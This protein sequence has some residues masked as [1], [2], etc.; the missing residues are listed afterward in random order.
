MTGG[1]DEWLDEWEVAEA[2]KALP[3]FKR[4]ALLRAA[5]YHASGSEYEGEDLLQ[6]VLVRALSGS[7]QVPRGLSLMTFLG[8]AMRSIVFTSRQKLKREGRHVALETTEGEGGHLQFPDGTRNA[9]EALVSQADVTERI[10]SLERLFDQD[11]EALMVLWGQ[12][13]GLKGA[14][15]TEACGLD[16]RQLGTAMRRIRRRIDAEYPKGWVL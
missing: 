13:D 15:L 5:N 6:E 1:S 12:M 10:D 16:S 4:A 2:I 8:N 3:P 9:E 7:R 14:E 11:E